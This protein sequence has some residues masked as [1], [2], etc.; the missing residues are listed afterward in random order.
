MNFSKYFSIAIVFTTCFLVHENAH[1]TLIKLT[2]L[3]PH[4]SAKIPACVGVDGKDYKKCT[5]TAYLHTTNSLAG[6]DPDFKKSFDAWNTS[7]AATDKWTLANG[8]N[9]PGGQFEVSIFDALAFNNVG[10]L[11]INIDWT[12]NGTD[13][14]DFQWAQGLLDNYL[15]N[16]IKIVDP[17][18][19]M[20][21]N[22]AEVNK[23][24]LYPFQYADRSFYDK[25]LGPW[26]NS[27]FDAR[28]FLSKA[29]FTART[30]TIYEGVN[31]GF[32]LSVP[33]PSTLL[34]FILGV[35]GLVMSRRNNSKVQLADL[36]KQVFNKPVD[37][38]V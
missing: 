22:A 1:A 25:P 34:L 31:Y 23:P 12:Y 5:S 3:T 35:T 24:P 9:L 4:Y 18:Y 11:E 32:I 8:G 6:N 28:A 14:D 21:V 17:F 15:I 38:K 16:P 2:D 27:S 30:L 7:N 37:R 26:P 19:E 33:E 13:K 29:N 20:D 36:V 10:G